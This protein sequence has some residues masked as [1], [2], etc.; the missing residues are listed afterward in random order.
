M[1][2]WLAIICSRNVL[3]FYMYTDLF[4]WDLL[5]CSLVEG[6]HSMF[7]LCLTPHSMMLCRCHARLHRAGLQ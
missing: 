3:F 5:L 6:M 1:T 2:G 7:V 4:L